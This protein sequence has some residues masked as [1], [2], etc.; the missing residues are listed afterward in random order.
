MVRSEG[1][2][3]GGPARGPQAELGSFGAGVKRPVRPRNWVR[4]AYTRR[5]W[6]R[7]M[8]GIPACRDIGTGGTPYGVTT[9]PPAGRWLHLWWPRS[10]L[11]GIGKGMLCRG[12]CG[13]GRNHGRDARAT[14]RRVRSDCAKR[15]QF[16]EEGPVRPG[17]QG[18]A[19][20]GMP[21]DRAGTGCTGAIGFVWRGCGAEKVAGRGLHLRWPAE[22]RAGDRRGHVVP[23]ELRTW[24]ESRARR[25][26]YG[27]PGE[28]QLCETKP[29][30][31]GRVG[32]PKLGLGGRPVGE[33]CGRSAWAL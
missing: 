1:C 27:A 25:P 15:S 31:G 23:G 5:W 32:W 18:L 4:F 16:G 26:C 28:E 17:R 7:I 9:N 13:R 22:R 3:P 2:S 20:G 29:I 12:S 19:V 21:C 10:G 6:A 30:S 8:C 24:S 14:G 11:Q 33:R